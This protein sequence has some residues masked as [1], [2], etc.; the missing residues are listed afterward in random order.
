MEE[1]LDEVADVTPVVDTTD[2]KAP[3][4]KVIHCPLDQADRYKEYMNK[5]GIPF[6]ENRLMDE[7]QFKVPKK[8]RP[9]MW[10]V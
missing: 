6:E 9:S 1:Q 2:I 3:E 4:F 10:K 7:V 8:Y 5:K